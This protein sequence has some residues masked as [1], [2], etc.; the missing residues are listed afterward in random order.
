MNDSPN[1]LQMEIVNGNHDND[2]EQIIRAAKIR[3]D[4]L[5]AIRDAEV[6]N[7]L[8]KGDTV[9]I[10]D[11]AQI[12]PK[13]LLGLTCK[14]IKVNRTTVSIKAI[15]GELPQYDKWSGPFRCPVEH[16]EVVNTA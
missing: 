6:K 4:T 16:L 2:L 5:K 9:R 14:V 12:R 10:S 7:R 11:S 15:E 8:A 13:K 1:N 3:Q